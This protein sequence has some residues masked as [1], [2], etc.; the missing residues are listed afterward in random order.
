[1]KTTEYFKFK[2]F[3]TNRPVKEGK[4]KKL[5]ESISEFGFIEGRKILI[6]DDFHIIDGQHRFTACAELKLP[7]YYEIDRSGVDPLKLMVA[8]NRT[9]DDWKLENYLHLYAVK[10][11]TFHQTILEFNEKYKLGIYSS[12]VLCCANPREAKSIKDG[13]NKSLNPRREE[14]A[15][16][17]IS[18]NELSFY[19]SQ[20]FASAICAFFKKAKKEDIKKL[21]QKRL[22]ITQQPTVM[23]F[24][25]VFS[26]IVN[27]YKPESKK[28]V[29]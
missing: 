25:N 16:F 27:R 15:Q 29:F 20:K 4:V 13:K 28:I 5:K 18:C 22:S 23:T 1:M 21:Y 6:T 9:Q 10:G 2:L 24:L 8:L 14:L 11:I 7:I 12:L 17:I 26:N 19:K 3:P